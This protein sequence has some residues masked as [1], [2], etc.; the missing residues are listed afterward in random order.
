[1]QSFNDLEKFSDSFQ[2]SPFD[3]MEAKKYN[4]IVSIVTLRHANIIEDMQTAVLEF[5]DI[6][7]KSA[8]NEE[9]IAIQIFL[10][11]F[12][13]FR[14]ATRQLSIEHLYATDPKTMFTRDSIAQRG[15]AVNRIL[16]EAYKDAEALCKNEF[17]YAPK[18]SI[19]NPG[20]VKVSAVP[21]HMHY[22]IDC[23]ILAH[24]FIWNFFLRPTVYIIFLYQRK[25][26]YQSF[27]IYFLNF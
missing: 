17:F 24:V 12:Y 21:A 22:R 7:K 11:R 3:T 15:V 19:E 4:A 16:L 8:S 18:L 2:A 10:D 6:H 9:L 25:F 26:Y 27:C 20:N 5:H 23:K 1:M 14:M 13:T